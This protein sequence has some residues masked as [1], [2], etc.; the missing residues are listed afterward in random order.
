MTLEEFEAICDQ[1]T[2][3]LATVLE[4]Q[5]ARAAIPSLLQVLGL[6]L[7]GLPDPQ[8]Q[9]HFMG[10]VQSQIEKLHAIIVT[11]PISQQH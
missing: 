8:L 7:M 9:V 5:D 3:E 2:I 10:L 6:V 11:P 1:L 4:D